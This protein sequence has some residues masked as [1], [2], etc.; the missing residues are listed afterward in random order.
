MLLS[1]ILA[2]TVGYDYGDKEATI[3]FQQTKAAHYYYYDKAIQSSARIVTYAKEEEVGHASSNYF[4]IGHHNF[5]ITAAHVLSIEG[6]VAYAIDG[7]DKVKLYPAILDKENDLLFL[8][9][10]RK[11][12]TVKPVNY[13]VNKEL[14]ILGKTVLY[15]G[16]PADLD[17][18]LFHGTIATYGTYSFMMQSFALPGA[19][20]AVVFDN[21][22]MPIGVLSAIKMGAY[23]ISPFPQ[24]HGTLVFVNRLR[25]YDKYVLEEMLSKW[26]KLKSER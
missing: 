12:K 15:A 10:E 6:E 2:C 11:L 14:D 7:E 5:L 1:L 16:Y 8:V 9:P 4:K 20:G 3:S 22:G 17:K 18:S 25:Q 23:G 26:K 19:S 13:V 21:K 24:L